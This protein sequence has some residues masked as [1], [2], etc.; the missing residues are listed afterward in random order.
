[1]TE[2]NHTAASDDAFKGAF[3][4][5]EY[6]VY[7]LVRMIQIVRRLVADWDF[8]G[9]EQTD[10][11]A[12]HKMI[13][14][15]KY[16]CRGVRFTLHRRVGFASNQLSE[17][18]AGPPAGFFLLR[19]PRESF[20]LHRLTSRAIASTYIFVRVRISPSKSRGARSSSGGYDCAESAMTESPFLLNDEV[21]AISRMGDLA[22][23]RLE[24]L[25]RFPRRIRIDGRRVAWRRIDIDHWTADPE[26]WGKQHADC[27][28]A[29]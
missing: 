19:S 28:G 23:S 7:D 24:K 8:T 1:M 16:S 29:L 21:E 26:G 2:Q 27:S 18:P 12:L 3:L 11:A 10:L 20:G 15:H 4:K 25:G 13:D 9:M 14:E 22:R 17:E 6:E 5:L